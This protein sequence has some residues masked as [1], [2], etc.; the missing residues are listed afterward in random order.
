MALR[1][2]IP[3][4]SPSVP[5]FSLHLSVGRYMVLLASKLA[6]A[7]FRLLIRLNYSVMEALCLPDGAA[8]RLGFACCRR[9]RTT[10]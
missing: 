10:T 4:A 6:S 8:L 9:S 1:A 3:Y 5:R 2:D 7:V